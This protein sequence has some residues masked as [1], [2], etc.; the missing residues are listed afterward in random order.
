MKNKTVLPL[1]A[2]AALLFT[3]C[4]TMPKQIGKMNETLIALDELGLT[5]VSIPGRV[6]STTY[7]REE[8]EG[9]IVS[10]LMHSNPGLAGPIVIERQRPAPGVE[11]NESK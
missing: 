10:T 1:A 5:K 4:S 9:Q 3:G 6:T 11:H 8:K 7:E 2:V